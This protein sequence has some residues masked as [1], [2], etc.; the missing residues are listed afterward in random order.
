M[1]EKVNHESRIR[2]EALQSGNQF[3]FGFTEPPLTVHASGFIDHKHKPFSFAARTK[4]ADA[5]FG[6]GVEHLEI[7]HGGSVP[8]H[9]GFTPPIFGRLLV[10]WPTPAT[11]K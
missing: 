5:L 8:L 2:L 1:V 4:E 9:G 11:E 6:S 10:H 7:L 3:P